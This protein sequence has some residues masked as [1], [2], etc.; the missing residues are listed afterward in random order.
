MA[1]DGTTVAARSEG[2]GPSS[3]STSPRASP[4]SR[5]SVIGLDDVPAGSDPASVIFTPDGR[6][7]V[8]TVHP[9]LLLFDPATLSLSAS[10]V[11]PAFSA[12][13]DSVMT[14]DGV[15]IASGEN[16][17]VA[18]D[19][20][21]G[22]MLWSH[23][24]EVTKPDSCSTLAAS[25]EL[26][27]MYCGDPWGG[28]H[29]TRPADRCTDPST[30]RPSMGT[31]RL[32]R[33]DREWA[34]ELLAIGSDTPALSLWST[35]GGAANTLGAHGKVMLDFYGGDAEALVIAG[36][37]AGCPVRRRSHRLLAVGPGGRSHGARSRRRAGGPRLGRTR[38]ADGL[39]HPATVTS[40]ASSVPPVR[41]SSPIQYPS[42]AFAS[43]PRPA[44]TWRT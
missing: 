41:A 10:V 30:I 21:S 18:V 15:L 22:R 31:H 25:S 36:T 43:G 11:V 8:G 13:Q 12:H 1:Q 6:I 32:A 5:A 33:T 27:T 16:S 38:P 28:D 20:V 24:L 26:G 4:G 35:D 9:E 44:E 3:R 7:A 34:A 23:E 42:R 29:R 2:T 19:T 40:S 17:T 37:S 14:T 39:L